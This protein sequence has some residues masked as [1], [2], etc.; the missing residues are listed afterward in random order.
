M[1]ASFSIRSLF[2]VLVGGDGD[3]VYVRSFAD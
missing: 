2:V 3:G 1:R